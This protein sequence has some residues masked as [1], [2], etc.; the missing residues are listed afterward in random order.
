M[1]HLDHA[2]NTF[3]RSF[4]DS[5][6]PFPSPI[7]PCLGRDFFADGTFVT[8]VSESNS[9]GSLSFSNEGRARA[10]SCNPCASSSLALRFNRLAC[11]F[12]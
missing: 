10:T 12:E 5:G 1:F 11:D 7:C 6:T 9:E 3:R 8:I 2:Y 4:L